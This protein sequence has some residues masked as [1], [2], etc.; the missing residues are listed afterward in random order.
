MTPRV[1]FDCVVLLQG[2]GRPSGPAGACVI[3]LDR[4]TLCF[5]PQIFAEVSDVH[6]RPEIRRRFPLLT[7]ERVETFLSDVQ[8]KAM[9]FDDVPEVFTY[10]RDPDDEPYIN[11]AL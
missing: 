3:L 9:F 11:L 7:D 8:T 1:V 10:S 5:S 4:F 2:A 6:N